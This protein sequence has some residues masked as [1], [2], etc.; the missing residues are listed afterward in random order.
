[1]KPFQYINIKANTPYSC[2]LQ[3]GTQAKCKITAGIEVYREFFARTSD[4][5][6]EEI[7]E[8]A[9][10]YVPVIQNAIP[11]VLEEAHG[12]ADGAKV[13]FADLMVLN[14]RYEITKFPK[15]S[16][17]TTAAILPQAT[18]DNSTYLVKNWDYKQAIIPNIVILHIE[19]PDGTV[20]LGLTEAGQMLREGFNSHGIGL[21]NNSLQSIYDRWDN[22]I[23]VTFLRRKVLSCRTF[24]KARDLLVHSKRSV[25]NNMM[26]AS[27]SG[28][29]I[30]I[31]AYP[32]GANMLAPKNGIITH[33]NHF[34]VHEHIDSRVGPKNRDLRL[35]WLLRQ[36]YGKIDIPFIMQ[37]MKDHEYYPESICAHNANIPGQESKD[38][39]TVASL[40]IDFDANEAWICA[41]PPCEGKYQKYKL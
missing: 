36:E 22:G 15:A 19:Q 21:V 31:E 40:I 3:Y 32:N 2:G 26:L 24:E 34:V 13:D 5:S 6:W 12:I 35:D 30:D 33:A 20:I 16:E 27:G 18:R 41:G 38:F 37:C 39:M 14:C 9:L 10:S 23:P 17:C 1:M 7:R 4:L 29:V 25:S 28:E 11:E 8:Y